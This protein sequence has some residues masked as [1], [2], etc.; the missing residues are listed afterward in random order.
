M[1][2]HGKPRS[3]GPVPISTNLTT[4]KS[5][6]FDGIRGIAIL[7]VFA[8]HVASAGAFA[9]SGFVHSVMMSGWLGVDL[10]FALS[11][12]LITASA[13]RTKERHSAEPAQY[14]ASFY[15]K[16]ALRILPAHVLWVGSVLLLANT[17]SADADRLALLN[18][19]AACLLL[20]C[21]N[22]QVALTSA[23]ATF[24]LNHIWSLA[25]EA[26][27]YVLWG[28]AAFFLSRRDLLISAGLLAA[29]SLFWRIFVAFDNGNWLWNYFSTPTRL[30]SFALGAACFLASHR[31]TMKLVV[32]CTLIA[33]S[34]MLLLATSSGGMF[35][36]HPQPQAFGIFL[37]G[38]IGAGIILQ[39]VSAEPSWVTR[40]LETRW[41][42]AL[43]TISYS[44][45]LSHF[46]VL[47]TVWFELSAT[48]GLSLG[49]SIAEDFFVTLG[50]A[51][52][53]I[54]VAAVSY[55]YIEKPFMAMARI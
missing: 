3:G 32:R 34:A 13:I 7:C 26:Q 6:A 49:R 25:V 27:I 38:L 45:Y 24:G 29:V 23:P 31:V 50:L 17:V 12:Y 11:G 51:S 10:F 43:G 40:V 46:I 1:E 37:M 9:Q 44:F 14:F 41:L 35:Y 47:G 5:Q 39:C 53:C 33:A 18:E 28:V 36:N 21:L 19:R 4:A 20:L 42:V 16:R 15:K 8:F 22:M 2:V 48:M 54:V 55:R 52:V 30:D